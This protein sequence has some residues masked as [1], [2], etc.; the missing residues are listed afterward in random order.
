MRAGGTIWNWGVRV[1]AVSDY[2]PCVHVTQ[3]KEKKSEKK[4]KKSEKKEKK[5]KK[6]SDSD[7]E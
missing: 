5:A 2:P 3:K 1:P 4:E 6:A 7:D